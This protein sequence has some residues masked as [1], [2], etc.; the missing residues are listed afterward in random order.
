MR[1]NVY[2]NNRLNKVTWQKTMFILFS[3]SIYL[4][5]R[6]SQLYVVF[7]RTLNLHIFINF[8]IFG[9]LT[10]VFTLF[11]NI[12]TYKKTFIFDFRPKN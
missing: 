3:L 6:K 11:F 4:Y 12:S 10:Y 9:N 5:F 2:V 8:F 1:R 7:S